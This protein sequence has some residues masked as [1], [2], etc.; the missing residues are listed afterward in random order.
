MQI[1]FIYLTENQQTSS[2]LKHCLL[3]K[4]LLFLLLA[5]SSFLISAQEHYVKGTIYQIDSSNNFA[6]AIK[7]YDFK[8]YYVRQ[9]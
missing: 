4:L 5:T 8:D 9:E 3:M 2:A 7:T 1:F 6:A